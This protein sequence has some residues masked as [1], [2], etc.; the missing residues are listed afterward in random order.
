MKKHVKR[1]VKKYIKKTAVVAMIVTV[2]VLFTAGESS[3]RALT[4]EA[5]PT[6]EDLDKARQEKN[7]L[8]NKKNELE[9]NIDDLKGEQKSL[10]GELSKLNTQLTE[11]S[12]NLEKLEGQI[13]DKEKEITDTQ[14]VLA[15]A[16]ETEQQQ[17]ADMVW[18][19]RKMYERNDQSNLNAVVNSLFD[20]SGFAEALNTADNYEKVA[21]YD[22]LK[23]DEFKENRQLIEEHEAL[24]QQEKVELDNLKLEAETQKNK[25]SGLVS[26][27][28]NSI[29][30]YANEI[31][32]AEKEALAY[33]EKIKAQEDVIKKIAEELAMSEAAANGEWRDI[34]EIEFAEGDRYLLANLIYCEAGGEPYEGQLAVGAVVINRVLSEKFPG[35]VVG[36]IYQNRQFSP[37]ASGRIWRVEVSDETI[38][39]V[40]RAL[41][42][43]DI[44]EGAL[45]F[46]ARK[47]ANQDKMRWFDTSLTYLFRHG[48][49][50]FFK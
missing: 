25:V 9:G 50:E 5:A 15:K 44:S 36:V 33:E 16:K 1:L 2:S 47:R 41:N 38:S 32:E 31:S 23:L 8:E 21:K 40:E 3:F 42:G 27:T 24:L 35:T 13:A 34:S 45:F 46:A 17:Y 22:K 28:S 10:K 7:E 30:K 29:N 18:R 19:V 49:H 14:A 20:E 43:E 6:Y 37:V 48:G 12:T 26:A 4:V 11:I 39:A